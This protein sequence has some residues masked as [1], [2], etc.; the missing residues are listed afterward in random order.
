DK[1][2]I[3]L[4]VNF[5]SLPVVPIGFPQGATRLRNTDL[6]INRT[7]SVDESKDF[8]QAYLASISYVDWNVGR[9]LDELEKQGLRE[10]TLIVFWS[11][12]RSEE[13]TSELQSR[14]N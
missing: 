4:P 13:H 5:S 3:Q 11:D 14:E 7:A 1:E 6:F 8:I 9:L 12:H 10:N 2:E